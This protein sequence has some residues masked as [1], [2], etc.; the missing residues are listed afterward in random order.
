MSLPFN[1]L[2]FDWDGTL[3]D[4]E[5]SIVVGMQAA[6]RDLGCESRNADSSKNTIGLGRR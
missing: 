2:V 4:S 6:I 5:A 1:L 3:M